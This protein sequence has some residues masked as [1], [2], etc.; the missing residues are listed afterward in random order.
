[1][2]AANKITIGR[3][4][5]VPVFI[6]QIIF[7]SKTGQ[8]A[9]RWWALASFTLASLG[10]ALDGFVARHFN[11]RTKLG[12]FLD[13][14]ADKL[15][16][17]CAII[18]MAFLNHRF[19]QAIPLW[20][21]AAVLGRDVIILIGMITVYSKKGRVEVRARWIGK[22]ATVLQIV[23]VYWI[24]LDWD[25]RALQCLTAAAAL[26][27]ALS[28]PLYILDGVRQFYSHPEGVAAMPKNG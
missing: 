25:G 14:L 12:A 8:P 19:L 6:S 2:T 3:I 18:L 15:M 10:D 22:I 20:L 27:T 1:M 7:F 23:A 16:L 4:V 17:T 11:Q 5:L 26:C 24:L 21:L 9:H 13:P 28:A